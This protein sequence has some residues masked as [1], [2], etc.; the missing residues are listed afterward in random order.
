MLRRPKWAQ[1]VSSRTVSQLEHQLSLGLSSCRRVE[2][3]ADTS[4]CDTA[5]YPTSLEIESAKAARI[6]RTFTSTSLSP[7]PADGH[8]ALTSPYH[9]SGHFRSTR[10][11]YRRRQEDSESTAQDPSFGELLRCRLSS[12]LQADLWFYRPSNTLRASPSSRCCGLASS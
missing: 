2:D 8:R 5:F 6:L 3:H 12:D 1:K 7:S 11:V 10:R 4:L 9:Y